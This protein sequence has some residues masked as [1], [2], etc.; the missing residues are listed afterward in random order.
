MKRFI[1][2]LFLVCSIASSRG[3]QLWGLDL[4]GRQNNPVATT[5]LLPNGSNPAAPTASVSAPPIIISATSFS[6]ILTAMLPGSS[7][8]SAAASSSSSTTSLQGGDGSNPGGC[9]A[10]SACLFTFEHIS[11]CN[12]SLRDGANTTQVITFQTCVC[13]FEGRVEDARWV[14]AWT[15][16]VLCFENAGVPY[17]ET[18]RLVGAQQ[19][20]CVSSDPDIRAFVKS[21]GI[22]LP[23]NMPT[24]V[25]RPFK[26]NT[27]STSTSTLT[28]GPTVDPIRTTTSVVS[29][30]T[31]TSTKVE[32]ASETPSA[33]STEDAALASAESSATKT[34]GA[35]GNAA[36][37]AAW[38]SVLWAAGVLVLSEAMGL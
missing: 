12:K 21:I 29:R 2:L 18:D 22:F 26:F 36:G 5:D 27:T 19:D 28:V 38:T 8:S 9:P 3:F 33:T 14:A 30:S 17:S 13:N 25:S 15:D 31:F 4:I 20:F 23:I 7:A 35:V 16:C 37:L 6:A 34:G 32:M 10:T 24:S 1:S 11:D